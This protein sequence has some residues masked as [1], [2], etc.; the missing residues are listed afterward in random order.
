MRSRSLTTV[1]GTIVSVR[2]ISKSDPDLSIRDSFSQVKAEPMVA[3]LRC[4]G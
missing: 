2:S 1:G 3:L 4:K